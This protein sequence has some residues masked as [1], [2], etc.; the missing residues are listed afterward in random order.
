MKR[1]IFVL[2]GLVF[3]Q[4]FAIAALAQEQQFASIGDLKLQNG[5][6]IRNC[7]IGYRTFGKLNSN[8]SNVVVF[9]TWAG[10]TTE[11]LQSSIGPGKLVDSTTY[12]VVAIDALS[13]GITSSPSNSRLQPR[14]RFPQFTLRDTVESQ[15][16]VLT[17]VVKVDHVKAIVG[18]SM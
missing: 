18:I 4:L 10:G 16:G 9:P 7:R 12:F 15:H 3:L 14:M 11:Q 6:V 5:G 17:K 1:L 2:C 8:T 13:N